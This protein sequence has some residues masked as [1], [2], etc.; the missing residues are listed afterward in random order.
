MGKHLVQAFGAI[1]KYPERQIYSNRKNKQELGVTPSVKNLKGEK[2]KKAV[3][4]Y[5]KS[6][7][8]NSFLFPVF[9]VLEQFSPEDDLHITAINGNTAVIPCDPPFSVPTVVTSFL[10]NG[11]KIDRSTDNRKLMSSGDLQIFN[12]K[13]EDAGEYKCIAY[14]PFLAEKVMSKRKIMLQ[15]I[16]PFRPEPPS[17][18]KTP[19]AKIA[20]ALGSNVTVECA[21]A[22]HPL[23]V[24]SWRKHHGKLPHSRYQQIGGNLHII[25]VRRGDEGVYYCEAENSVGNVS[26][27][28]EIEIQETP[29]ILKS[30]KSISV[31]VG[32]NMTL[33]CLVHGHPKPLVTWMHN[34]KIV[35]VDAESESKESHLLITNVNH[36]HSGIYQCFANNDLGTVYSATIVTVTSGNKS[37]DFDYDAHNYDDYDADDTI[38]TPPLVHESKKDLGIVDKNS[39]DA[40]NS[41]R[42]KLP[43]FDS[44]SSPKRKKKK[45]S[46]GVKLVPPSKPEVTRLSNTSVMVRWGVPRNDGLPILFFKVQYKEVGRRKTDWMTIDEDIAAHIHSYAVTNLRVGGNYRFRIAAVYSNNDNKSGPVSDKFVLSKD[47]PM[48]KPS[49]APM[50][51]FAEAASPS[52]ITL[53]WEYNDMDSVPTE[54]FFIHYRAT[55]TAGKYLKVTVLGAN[56]RS[57]I[58]SHLLPDT[59]YDIKMQAFNDAGPSDFSNIYTCKTKESEALLGIRNR[60]SKSHHTDDNDISVTEPVSSKNSDGNFILYIALGVVSGGLLIAV[61]VFLA[62]FIRQRQNR[63]PSIEEEN[64]DD[65]LKIGNGHITSNGYIAVGN[66][67]NISVNPLSHLDPDDDDD[68]D[69]PENLEGIVS[70]NNEIIRLQTFNANTEPQQESLLN[71]PEIKESSLIDCKNAAT[72][73]LPSDSGTSAELSDDIS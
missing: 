41:G 3:P 68:D 14:N 57:H 33:S 65:P 52:A 70:N 64:P 25:G 16:A 24:V 13:P 51:T 45:H 36:R 50:I 4:S 39:E 6:V 11:S 9:A 2:N 49:V 38:S 72:V 44:G 42:D 43:N 20:V 37:V 40:L 56:T 15:V 19:R 8:I 53:H 66:K 18:V 1:D 22:G 7:L 61:S 73:I 17:F 46:K 30:P 62:L 71:N 60:N 58:I 35:S 29:Q 5:K 59:G 67:V 63:N 31:E 55:H 23:P 32:E 48:E 28:T 12:V 26:S 27:S 54:G 34:G 47:T 10:F 21:V 69:K